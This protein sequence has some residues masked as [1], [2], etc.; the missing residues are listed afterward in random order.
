MLVV[1]KSPVVVMLATLVVPRRVALVML[2]ALL[3]AGIPVPD[4]PVMPYVPAMET[5]G[6][7]RDPTVRA[8]VV[9][10]LGVIAPRL[11]VMTG[12]VLLLVVTAPIPFCP[13]ADTLVTVPLVVE[14]L[15]MI[16]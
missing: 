13:I 6:P 2:G 16:G 11:S 8:F 9:T 15:L 5:T 3:Y 14:T 1:V 12:V 7:V 10:E 4:C